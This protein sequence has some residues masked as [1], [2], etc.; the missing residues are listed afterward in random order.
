MTLTLDGEEIVSDKSVSN[1][2]NTPQWQQ[3]TLPTEP[4][5]YVYTL[6]HMGNTV[7]EVE[8]VVEEE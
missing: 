3:V 8:Y 1:G 6:T 2:Y 5:T 4:G 7:C